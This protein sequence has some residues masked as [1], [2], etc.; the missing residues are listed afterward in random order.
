MLQNKFQSTTTYSLIPKASVESVIKIRNRK[1]KNKFKEHGKNRSTS[2]NPLAKHLFKKLKAGEF[3]L[4][5]EI[6]IQLDTSFLFS[7]RML[8]SQDIIFFDF[9][10]YLITINIELSQC[11]FTDKILIGFIFSF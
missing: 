6:S 1:Y 7:I 8:F 2:N 3:Q 4:K 5:K 11:V 9:T 10:F